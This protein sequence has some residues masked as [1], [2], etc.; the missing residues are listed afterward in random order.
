MA[1]EV[2]L[3]GWSNRSWQ[4]CCADM[5]QSAQETK[6][7]LDRGE[8]LCFF[9]LSDRLVAVNAPG[10]RDNTTYCT[11]RFNSLRPL[12]QAPTLQALDITDR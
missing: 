11:P 7:S 8:T 4:P 9:K 3:H 2:P 5:D 1:G 6:T 10:E 12:T